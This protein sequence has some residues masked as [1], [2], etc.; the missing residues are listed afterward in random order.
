MEGDRT[1]EAR[2]RFSSDTYAIGTTGI[3][4]EQ[5]DG[6]HAVCTLRIGPRHLNVRGQVM[7]GAIFTLA[8]FAFGVAANALPETDVVTAC[9]QIQFLNAARGSVLT[10]E[11]SCLKSGRTTCVMDVT[12]RDDAGTLVAKAVMTGIRKRS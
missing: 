4:I 11:T 9:A 2:E 7:G 12:I 10:A 8:D 3:A 6:L 1:Q 5:A